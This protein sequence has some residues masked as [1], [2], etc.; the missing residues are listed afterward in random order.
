VYALG[1]IL[2]SLI[3]TPAPR[4][5]TAIA[6]RASDERLEA[7]YGTVQDLARDVMRFRDGEPVE[8]YKEAPFERLSR[9]YRRYQLPVMLVLAY[10]IMRV[11]LLFWRGV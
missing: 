1:V 3:T 5:L 2:A 6:Q 11:V 4:P 8:A 10:V 9:L 7:R